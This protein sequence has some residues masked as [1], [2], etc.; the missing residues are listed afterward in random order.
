M[1]T[2]R[3]VIDNHLHT[4]G[5]RDLEGILS[6]YA[7]DAI[8]FTAEGPLRG[9]A[10]IRELLRAMMG[11]FAKPGAKF[12]LD[13]L[14]VDGEYGYIAWTAETADNVYE[15]ATDTFVVREGKIAVQSFAAKKVAKLP[16][17]EVIAVA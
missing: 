10:S 16:E 9:I 4:F 3:A 7:P 6:D 8:L 14:F 13:R 5:A 2:T 11:E 1:R 17:P 15:L 12:R